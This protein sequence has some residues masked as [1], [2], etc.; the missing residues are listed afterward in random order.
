MK[1]VKDKCI[2]SMK[3]MNLEVINQTCRCYQEVQR[4]LQIRDLYIYLLE[5]TVTGSSCRLFTIL[6]L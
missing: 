2:I 6:F 3:R 5:F 4:F 1:F